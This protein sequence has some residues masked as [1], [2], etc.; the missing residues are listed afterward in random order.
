MFVDGV[1]RL[2]KM[3]RADQLKVHVPV[4]P[5]QTIPPNPSP[6]PP[7]ALP[8][9]KM[10]IRQAQLRE[11][12]GEENRHLSHLT[13]LPNARSIILATDLRPWSHTIPPADPLPHPYP[14]DR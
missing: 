8:Q 11:M 4:H 7:P 12:R 10:K 5:K 14:Y 3:K 2:E 6:S 13:H 1:T 9:Y